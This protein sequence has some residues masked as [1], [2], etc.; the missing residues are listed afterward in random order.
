MGQYEELKGFVE[1]LYPNEESRLEDMP[2]VMMLIYAIALYRLGE[3]SEL[4]RFL[5]DAIKTTAVT[6]RGILVQENI[7]LRANNRML[8]LMR[9]ELDKLPT[10]PDE[11]LFDPFK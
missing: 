1:D 9:R 3:I 6:P 4:K 7:F 8:T 11:S 10:P 2:A 5:N